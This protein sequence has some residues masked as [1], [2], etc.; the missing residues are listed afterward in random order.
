MILNV[1]SLVYVY[2]YVFTYKK[3][4]HNSNRVAWCPPP[5]FFSS[6]KRG[7]GGGVGGG[8]VVQWCQILTS[9]LELRDFKNQNIAVLL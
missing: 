3:M 5:F 7:L 4:N 6:C 2:I 9:S 1:V 8:G